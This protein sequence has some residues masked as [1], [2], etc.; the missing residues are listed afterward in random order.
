MALLVIGSSGN[1]VLLTSPP[2]HLGPLPQRPPQGVLGLVAFVR[3]LSKEYYGAVKGT[4]QHGIRLARLS[5]RTNIVRKQ[6]SD[7]EWF[8]SL[9]P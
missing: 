8:R 1:I 9:F 6:K 7:D 4:S 5:A 3:G 2:S